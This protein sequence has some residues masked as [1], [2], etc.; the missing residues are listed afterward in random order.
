MPTNGP[1]AKCYP[2]E[3]QYERWKQNAEAAGMSVSEYIAS[4]VE[5][6]HKTF[7]VEVQPD[8][9]NVELRRE[10]NELADENERLR[11]RISALEDAIH[12]SEVGVIEEHI[13]QNP[14][15]TW[16]EVHDKVTFTASDRV[17]EHLETLEGTVVKK[18][19]DGYYPIERDD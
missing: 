10:R 11:D 13:R 9:S 18:R 17:I 5:A 19:N 6:G 14:G 12:R 2:D 16:Q 7:S 1:T 3:E 8:E 4:M 15:A